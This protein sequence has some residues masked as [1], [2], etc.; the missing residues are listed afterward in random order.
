MSSFSSLPSYMK[1]LFTIV[2]LSVVLI[3]G[4]RFLVADLF[5]QKEANTWKK[6]LESQNISFFKNVW[7]N[8]SDKQKCLDFLQSYEKIMDVKTVQDYNFVFF[9]YLGITKD[10]SRLEQNYGAMELSQPKNFVCNTEPTA[11]ILKKTKESITIKNTSSLAYPLEGTLFAIPSDIKG[12]A[13]FE[14]KMLRPNKE[15][16]IH[17]GNELPKTFPMLESMNYGFRIRLQ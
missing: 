8:T 6:H 15:A 3:L 7:G 5:L 2:I 17:F 1:W 12:T 11:Q 4:D 9:S 10:S 14:G 13:I 16:T